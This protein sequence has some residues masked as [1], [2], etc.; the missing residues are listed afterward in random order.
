LGMKGSDSAL[1]IWADFM[2]Q[3]LNLHPEWNGDWQMPD[4]IKKAEI[5]SRDG[6]FLR[7][8]DAKEAENIEAQQKVLKKNKE[9]KP[10]VMPT[11]EVISNFINTVPLEFRRVEL[12]ISGTIPVNLNPTDDLN[13]NANTQ[14]EVTP[15][16]FE[17][18]EESQAG[19][20]NKGQ[21]DSNTNTAKP[22]VTQSM[23]VMVCELSGMRATLNCP[24]KEPKTFKNGTE[25]KEFCT[26]H[27]KA[28]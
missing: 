7:E 5:D 28:P 14:P 1:P 13:E 10:E 17:T 23:T 18:W 9:E 24:K 21:S 16:P 2:R 22:Q 11:P 12:F 20:K 6:K 15:T 25:P 8:I 4:S 19:S 26:F 3:A 27:S